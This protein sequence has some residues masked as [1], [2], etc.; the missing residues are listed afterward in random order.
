MGVILTGALFDGTAGLLAVRV[1]GGSAVDQEPRDS[2]SVA[3]PR[4]A[5]QIAHADHVVPLA[6]M[7]GLFVEPV[8]NP[9]ETP[10]RGT[11]ALDP[12]DRISGMVDRHMDQQ[13]RNER[14]GE[15]SVFNCPGCG[16]PLWQTDDSS[17][18]QFRCHVGHSYKAEVLLSEQSEALE[19]ALWTSVR[20]F[21]EK[22]VL[23]RQLADREQRQGHPDAARFVEQVEQ[24]ERYSVLIRRYVLM[25]GLAIGAD[26][27][28]PLVQYSGP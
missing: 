24:S 3:M 9:R 12:I 21:R 18:I 26:P 27:A 10:G 14:R 16:G 8:V 5:A 17:L 13:S 19:A 4:R 7:P 22:S 1:G 25:D 28:V 20:T 15:T 6:D 11:E 23:A 2:S